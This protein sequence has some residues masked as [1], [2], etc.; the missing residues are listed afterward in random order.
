M[1]LAAHQPQYLPWL[2]YF[3]KMASCDVFVYLDDVQYKKR[4]FQNRNKIR[5]K[6]GVQW[7]TVPVI[8][9][10]HY[11]QAISEVRVDPTSAWAKDHWTAVK[12]AYAKASFFPAYAQELESFYRRPWTRLSDMSR[13]LIDFHRRVLNIS[14]PVRLSSEFSLTTAKTQRLLDL[15]RALGADTYLSGQGA[16][17]YLEEDLF[18]KAGVRLVYQ[19]FSHPRYAQVHEPFESHLAA[20][21]LVLNHGPAGADILMGRAAKGR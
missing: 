11:D 15:C 3:H 14:T 1:I 9:K 2:G 21:D 12:L 4:E 10:G 17:D 6:E 5:V 8:T 16:R 7:L 19:D 18:E 13:T 20:L